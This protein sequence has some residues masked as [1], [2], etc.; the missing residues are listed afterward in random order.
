MA[1]IYIQPPPY[2]YP[3]S[4]PIPRQGMNTPL[5]LKKGQL[6]QLIIKA[7]FLIVKK[8]LLLDIIIFKLS[9][10]SLEDL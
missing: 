3:F 1:R 2:P 5:F 9:I 7:E 6:D 8:L 4:L 10:P